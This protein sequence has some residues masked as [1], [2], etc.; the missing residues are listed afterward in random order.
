MLGL[1]R[2]AELGG[3]EDA[4]LGPHPLQ[5]L[6]GGVDE[7]LVD[8]IRHGEMRMSKLAELLS[9]D[10]SVTSRHVAHVAERGWIE[11]LPD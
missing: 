3:A 1:E 2:V 10:M 8:G 4:G 7:A 11:R 6:G 5:D 9:V